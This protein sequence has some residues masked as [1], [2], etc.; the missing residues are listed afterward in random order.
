MVGAVAECVGATVKEMLTREQEKAVA[1]ER[2]DLERQAGVHEQ[3][4]SARNDPFFYLFYHDQPIQERTEAERS[5]AKRARREIR[6]IY[7]S[8][9]DVSLRCKMIAMDRK[10]HLNW[11]QR[12]E[13]YVREAEGKLAEAER[14]KDR[15][16]WEMAAL[17]GGGAVAVG[18]FVAG[19]VGSIGGAVVGF[20]LGQGMIARAKSEAQNAVQDAERW[21]KEIR[22]SWEEARA[23]PEYFTVGEEVSGERDGTFD[24]P[25]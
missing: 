1:A 14:D 21:L 8:I 22:E 2:D 24:R 4:G 18:Y 19:L 23:E 11:L 15:Q 9:N 25:A 12:K 17:I 6:D 13:S 3:A 16:P 5:K 10:L 7:F 20:F